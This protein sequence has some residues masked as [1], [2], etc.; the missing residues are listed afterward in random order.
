MLITTNP[1]VWAEL[2]TVHGR[3]QDK[4][5]AFM[6]EMI[7]TLYCADIELYLSNQSKRRW[8]GDVILSADLGEIDLFYRILFEKMLS[9]PED[10][11][12]EPSPPWVPGT[13]GTP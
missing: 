6:D 3:W 13:L 2:L 11:D 5:D 1:D 9:V 7:D 10:T 4:A 12:D 8:P